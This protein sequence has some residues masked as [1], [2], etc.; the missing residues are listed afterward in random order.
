MEITVSIMNKR[1]LYP[2]SHCQ[3]SD[4]SP[5]RIQW[6]SQLLSETIKPQLLTA[7]TAQ[8]HTFGSSG[9]QKEGLSGTVMLITEITENQWPV[10]QL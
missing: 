9:T 10:V 3:M 8:I 1:N 5:Q 4:R 6:T 2:D 7:P